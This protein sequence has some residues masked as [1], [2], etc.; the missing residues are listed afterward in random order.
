MA[1]MYGFA[2]EEEMTDTM[3]YL[4]RHDKYQLEQVCMSN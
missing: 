3:K 2:C 4:H 1:G